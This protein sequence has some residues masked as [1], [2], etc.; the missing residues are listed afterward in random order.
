MFQ[1]VYPYN[2]STEIELTVSSGEVVR[3]VD[4][5]DL[6]GNT[7]WWLVESCASQKGYVPAS[8]LYK[9]QSP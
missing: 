4:K 8:Y 3:V 7:E 1:A 5:H 6:D 9:I 2:A